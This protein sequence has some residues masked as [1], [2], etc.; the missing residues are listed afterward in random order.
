[1]LVTIGAGVRDSSR[2][3]APLAWKNSFPPLLSR[4]VAAVGTEGGEKGDHFVTLGEASWINSRH[5]AM[6]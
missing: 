5:G 6:G 1:M 4:G 3:N 2:V